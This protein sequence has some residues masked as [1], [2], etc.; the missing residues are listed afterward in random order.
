MVEGFQRV[1]IAGV[2]AALARR[3][4]R[5]CIAGV[6]PPPRRRLARDRNH[7][8][9][10]HEQ[11]DWEPIGHQGCGVPTVGVT[12]DGEVAA[13]TD[14]VDHGVG[15]VGQASGVVIAGQIGG[16]DVMPAP[17]QLR[18]NQVPRPPHVSCAVDQRERCHLLTSV[19]T[20]PVPESCRGESGLRPRSSPASR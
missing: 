19:P 16:D 2:L 20:A 7:S 8:G 14:R 3:L 13:V 12:D 17:S 6:V 4:H 10:E 5:L 1:V 15:V 18:L 9:H 11:V